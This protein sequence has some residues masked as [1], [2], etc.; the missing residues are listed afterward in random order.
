MRI[1]LISFIVASLLVLTAC[2]PIEKQARDTAAA[3]S[4]LLVTAQSQYAPSCVPN[5]TQTICQTI[6]RGISAQA[7]LI[8]SVETYCSWA[9]SLQ[10]PD[11]N[12]KCSP[13]KSAQAALTSAIANANQA[14]TDMKGVIK[15]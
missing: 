14:I 5:P 8:T 2:S 4:G 1:T 6:N 3:L 15:P 11:A 10:P 9:I 7:L 13:V 12:A